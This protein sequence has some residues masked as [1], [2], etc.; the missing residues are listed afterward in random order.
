[1]HNKCCGLDIPSKIIPNLGKE[2]NER[3]ILFLP[4]SYVHFSKIQKKTAEKG[5][6]GRVRE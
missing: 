4:P 5:N 6:S 2:R 3:S 1:L